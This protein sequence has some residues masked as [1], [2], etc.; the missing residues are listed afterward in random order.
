MADTWCDS[1]AIDQH[2]QHYDSLGKFPRKALMDR[3]GSKHAVKMYYDLKSGGSI[4]TGYVV[5][6]LWLTVY[7]VTEFYGERVQHDG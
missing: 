4:H 2:G 6:N 1:M 7:R 5:A 3:L